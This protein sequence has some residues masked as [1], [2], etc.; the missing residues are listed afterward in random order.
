M[1]IITLNVWEGRISEKLFDFIEKNKNEVDV[2]CFQEVYLKAEGKREGDIERLKDIRLDLFTEMQTIL[3]DFEGYFCPVIEDHS[4]IATFIKKGIEVKSSGD[5]SIYD[6]VADEAKEGNH[7]R[8]ALW[9][10]LIIQEK[11]IIITNLHGLWTGKGKSDSPARILQSKIIKDFVNSN[12][13]SHIVVGD[14]NLLPDT[15]SIAIISEGMNDLVSINNIKNTRTS[16]YT[17]EDKYADY[18]F[19][20]PELKIND[21]KVLPDEVSDHAPLLVEIE[22]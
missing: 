14:F 17:K 21:F 15:Q 20:S 19:T 1:K 6:H 18:I 16:F 11:E 10:K 3:S 12:E 8:R 9:N 2:F 4:G 13:S 22:I 7:A 5:F